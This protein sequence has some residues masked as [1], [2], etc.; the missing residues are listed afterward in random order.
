MF[1]HAFFLVCPPCPSKTCQC[2]QKHTLLFSGMKINPINTC[3]ACVFLNLS[4]MSFP[5]FVN[6]TKN[7]PFF[8]NFARFCSPK[9]CTR[10]H[11]LVLK[12]N[13]NYIFFFEDD[14][15][16]QIQVPLQGHASRVTK[17][18]YPDSKVGLC[19]SIGTVSKPTTFIFNYG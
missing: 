5:K 11:C 3:F 19:N 12:N 14:I 18:P 8:S 1:L 13:P 6:M 17:R 2:D 9:Q 7:T 10:V 16:L 4:T 15:Q